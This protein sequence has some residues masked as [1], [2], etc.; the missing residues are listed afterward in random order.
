[1]IIF[2]Q[3]RKLVVHQQTITHAMHCSSNQTTNSHTKPVTHQLPKPTIHLNQQPINQPNHQPTNQPNIQPNHH[4]PQCTNPATTQPTNLLY[5]QTNNTPTNPLTHYS[6]TNQTTCFTTHHPNQTIKPFNPP[7][8]QPTTNQIEG[9]FANILYFVMS[10]AEWQGFVCPIIKRITHIRAK[11]CTTH[12]FW[13]SCIQE[14]CIFRS[15][16]TAL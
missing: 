3:W 16:R 6:T 15:T 1:M 10:N 11:V 8:T 4:P 2:K 13:K 5:F 12:T 9:L 7:W 14:T